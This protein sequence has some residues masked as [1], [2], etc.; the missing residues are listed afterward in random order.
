MSDQGPEL[1]RS[2]WATTV[3]REMLME[4]GRRFDCHTELVI[5]LGWFLSDERFQVAV[6]GNPNAVERM[7]AS[8]RTIYARAKE[9]L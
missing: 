3:S 9:E 2:R 8:A 1:Q 5:A 6:G 7:L 4:M